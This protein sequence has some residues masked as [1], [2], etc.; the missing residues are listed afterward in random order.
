MFIRYAIS[1]AYFTVIGSL[2]KSFV[3][4]QFSR[5]KLNTC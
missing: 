5:V 2:Q 1:L 3:D 4:A